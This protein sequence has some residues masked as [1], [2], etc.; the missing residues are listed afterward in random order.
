MIRDML[1]E[2]KDAGEVRRRKR[3]L[4]VTPQSHRENRVSQLLSQV[5]CKLN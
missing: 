4:V 2:S 3:G 1:R 5:Q